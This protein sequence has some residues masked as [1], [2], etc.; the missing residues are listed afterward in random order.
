MVWRVTSPMY[1]R[2]RFVLDAE[3]TPASFAEL[4]RRYSISR[5]SGYRWLDRYTRLGPGSLADRSARSCALHAT[6]PLERF[7]GTDQLGWL[8]ERDYRIHNRRGRTER[9]RHLSPIT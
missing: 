7:F 5:K 6:A 8:D 3:H 4:Y 1:Q 9:D 2:Q